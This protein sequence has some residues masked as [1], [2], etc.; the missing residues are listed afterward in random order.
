MTRLYDQ[1]VDIDPARVRQFFDD[2]AKREKN[3][4]NAVMLQSEGSSI[5]IERDRYE[6]E[7]LLPSLPQPG[8]I[9]DLGCGAG[10]LA[11]HYAP[12]GHTYMGIDFSSELIVK[13][14]ELHGDNPKVLFEIAEVPKI[15][16]ANL[17]VQ[18]PFDL[19]VVTGLLIY[20]NDGAV[21]E[22]L[23]LLGELAAPTATIYL[24]ESVSDIET[25]LTL[26]DFYSEELKEYYNGVYRTRAELKA[27]F[28]KTLEHDRFAIAA[29]GY[30]FQGALRN[31]VET[32]QY[33]YRF[34]RNQ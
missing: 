12:H 18:P 32:T 20:L 7:N 17:P 2:R 22:T 9:L 19:I 31:R 21:T 30:V 24:R 34:E 5:A 11:T 1:A 26:K 3:A 4:I 10:R 33:F 15:D 25:R 6:R 29:E 16:V 14:R 27:E 13:G 23:R 28:A 8:K